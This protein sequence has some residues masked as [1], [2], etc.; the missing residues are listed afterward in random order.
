[1]R[2]LDSVDFYGGS[3]RSQTLSLIKCYSFIWG[4]GCVLSN[5]IFTDFPIAC[6][7]H[8]LNGGL[9]QGSELNSSFSP[10]P[11]LQLIDPSKEIEECEAVFSDSRSTVPHSTK[12]HSI[13]P[14]SLQWPPP[15]G[16]SKKIRPPSE[17]VSPWPHPHH[18]SRLL[19]FPFAFDFFFFRF[20]ALATASLSAS[21]DRTCTL[22]GLPKSATA[23]VLS[24]STSRRSSHASSAK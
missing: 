17:V 18:S 1:M 22:T 15:D 8:T 3:W 21:A 9:V 7:K 24:P 12:G 13:L 5:I 14:T 11:S 2:C 16:K 6:S 10:T 20:P 19:F 23:S 4:C